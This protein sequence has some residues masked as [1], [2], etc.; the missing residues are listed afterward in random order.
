MTGLEGVPR[1]WIEALLP[2]GAAVLLLVALAQA[3]ALLLGREPPHLPRGDEDL[4]R[5][6]LARGE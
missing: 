4:P 5:D 1:W 2:A 3:L 6:T